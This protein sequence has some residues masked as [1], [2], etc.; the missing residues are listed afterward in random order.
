MHDRPLLKPW[1]LRRGDRV[2]VV[3]PASPVPEDAFAEGVAEL[4]RLGFD[5]VFDARVLDRTGYTAGDAA[6][7]ARALAEAFEDPSI[8]AIVSARGG[9]GSV[10]VLPLLRVDGIVRRPKL[11]VGYSDVTAVM[12]FLTIR[13]GVVALHG[14]CVA[15]G[16]HGGPVGYDESTLVRA[17]TLAEPLGVLPAPGLEALVPG[18]AS[19][20]LFGGNL[21]QLAASL[22]TPYRF[23]PPIGCVLLIEDVGERPYRIDRLLTQLR[24]AGVFD[25]A[26]AVVCGQFPGCDETDGSASARDVVCRA[27]HGFPGP[28]VWNAPVGHTAGP[29]LTLPLGVR[30][31]VVAGP[32][33]S[34]EVLEAAVIEVP[35]SRIPSP[36]SANR[37]NP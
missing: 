22:G 28:V 30:A 13:C 36:E 8:A 5:P 18:D 35:D 11:F 2:A 6:A 7:R 33:P 23:E 10:E 9:Y 21:T 29:A 3:A 24:F 1:A 17:M 32:C 15:A 26:C 37:I 34:V 19:G 14:P 27:L 25:R 31:R 4:R 16:L 20:P 12:T